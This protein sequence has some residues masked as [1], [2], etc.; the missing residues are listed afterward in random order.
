MCS[1][2]P[3]VYQQLISRFMHSLS[4]CVIDVDW[5][6]YPSSELSVLRASLLCDGRANHRMS[7]VMSSC[8]QNNSAVQNA[9]LDQMAV[10]IGKN[11]QVINVMRQSRGSCRG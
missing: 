7:K 1:D 9:F 2:I 11:K 3:S 5:S 10:A 6:G 4:F 8:Y